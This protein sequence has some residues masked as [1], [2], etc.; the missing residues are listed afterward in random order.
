MEHPVAISMGGRKAAASALRRMFPP[1]PISA[2][3][4]IWAMSGLVATLL[5][6][7]AAAAPFGCTRS[8]SEVEDSAAATRPEPTAIPHVGRQRVRNDGEMDPSVELT[9]DAELSR[10]FHAIEFDRLAEARLHLQERLS[11]DPDDGVAL[12]LFGLTFHRE[13]RYDMARRHFERAIE[14]VPNYHPLHHF[15]GWCLY[16]LGEPQ[17]ARAAFERHLRLYPGEGDSHFGIGLI[18]LDQD[19]LTDAIVHFRTALILHSRRDDRQLAVAN[20]HAKLGEAMQR[21]GNHES[22]RGY[23]EL[24]VALNPAHHEA[25]YQL[26]RVLVALGDDD[27][28]E[29]ALDAHRALKE[30]AGQTH[31]PEEPRS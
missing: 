2:R 26:A 18:E 30:R 15:Y 21:G 13:H 31:G 25:W 22:A 20:V 1:P 8:A 6:V 5:V 16:Y 9:L 17:A 4:E 19:N 27:G 28:A 23:F 11:R 24:A 12:F 29:R 7:M 3:L 10:A 14:L